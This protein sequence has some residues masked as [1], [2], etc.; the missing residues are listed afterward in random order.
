MLVFQAH[1]RFSVFV[2]QTKMTLEDD[3]DDEDGIDAFER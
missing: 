1:P 3:E 2:L